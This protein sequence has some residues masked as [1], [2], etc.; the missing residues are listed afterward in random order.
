[1]DAG[2]DEILVAPSTVIV[3]ADELCMYAWS[4]KGD[5]LGHS[6][7]KMVAQCF[8]E[9]PRL[10]EIVDV[11]Y[12]LWDWVAQY[13]RHATAAAAVWQEFHLQGLILARRLADLLRPLAVEVH[14][15]CHPDAL[16]HPHMNMGP[17]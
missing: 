7:L 12:E 9:Y 14:Y 15:R 6:G 2:A 8:A 5:C 16:S 1:M 3:M 17:L 11:E 13:P 10:S 4:E